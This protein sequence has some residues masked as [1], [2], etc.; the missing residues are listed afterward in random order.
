MF[1]SRHIIQE[2]APF[3]FFFFVLSF[4]FQRNESL[5]F[6]Q[7]K[8]TKIN[9]SYSLQIMGPFCKVHFKLLLS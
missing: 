6:G 9:G 8:W 4:Q 7:K 2:A 3:L 1:V 5:R